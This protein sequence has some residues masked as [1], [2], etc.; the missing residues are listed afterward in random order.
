MQVPVAVGDIL[1][2]LI[3]LTINKHFVLKMAQLVSRYWYYLL[4][5]E[6]FFYLC[7]MAKETFW[8]RHDFDAADDDKTMLLIEQ[9]GLEG[10]GIYWVLIE[11]LRGR[12]GYKMPFSVIPSLARRYMTSPEKMKTVITQFNL[13]QYDEEGFFYSMSLIERMNALNSLKEK[14]SNA[15]RLGM[16]QRWR[17]KGLEKQDVGENKPYDGD[18]EA[19]T[20]LLQCNNNVITSDND[21]IGLD[22]IIEKE[23]DKSSSKK[24]FNFKKAL[25]DLGVEECIATDWL[26]VRKTKKATNTETAFNRIKE[27]IRLSGASANDCI[28]FA[29][30]RSWS[31][32]KAEW[33]TKEVPQV[34]NLFN[35]TAPST[36]G[37]LMVLNGQIYR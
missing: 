34:N 23:E 33:Y 14:R 37:D 7:I 35:Q 12:E 17:S 29:V 6:S 22:L 16:Q 8:F 27:Q 15:G 18:N 24:K 1:V 36:N 30:E 4:N 28:T 26:A 11:K 3:F 13:F 9:L 31:G 10:Y 5:I 21:K 20:P 2:G 32:F 25:L 19:I